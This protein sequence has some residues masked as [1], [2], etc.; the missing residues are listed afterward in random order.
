MT[1]IVALRFRNLSEIFVNKRKNP[2]KKFNLNV[3]I[4]KMEEEFPIKVEPQASEDSGANIKL[5][6]EESVE[7]ENDNLDPLVFDGYELKST[8]KFLLL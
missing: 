6:P 7:S 1:K 3:K 2:F 5:E 4:N 8:G